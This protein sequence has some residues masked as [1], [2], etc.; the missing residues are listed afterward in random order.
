MRKDVSILQR[1]KHFF[2]IYHIYV[3]G[4]FYKCKLQLDKI[5]I[6]FNFILITKKW[7]TQ[8]LDWFLM[9]EI[10]KRADVGWKKLN[11]FE[12]KFSKLKFI[13]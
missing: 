3:T 9:H 6:E 1:A 2:R 4:Q 13:K 7:T 8:S 10:V 5:R 12:N 11:N